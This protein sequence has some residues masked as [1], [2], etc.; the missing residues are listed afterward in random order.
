MIRKYFDVVLAMVLFIYC[1]SCSGSNTINHV[2]KVQE[3]A[4]TSIHSPE[5]RTKVAIAKIVK[6]VKSNKGKKVGDGECWALAHEA[7]RA[8]GI[9]QRDRPG[10]RVW[11]RLVD[12]KKESVQ[13]GDILELRSA[14]FPYFRTGEYHT[15]VIVSEGN[16]GKFKTLEQNIYGKKYVVRNKYDLKTLSKGS[17]FVYRFE[18]K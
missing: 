1:S 3:K 18:Y 6:F 14:V 8:A 11:G 9:K 7:F 16:G 4:G 5:E 15:S 13:P 17:V 12:W 10:V 2:E